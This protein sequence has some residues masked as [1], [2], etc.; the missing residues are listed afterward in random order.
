MNQKAMRFVIIRFMPYIQTREF[1]NIGIVLTCPKTGWFNFQI[2]HRYARLGRFFKHFRADVYRA[3]VKTLTEQ[4]NF[5]KQEL[6]NKPAEQY[7]F[8]LDH[9]ALPREAIIQTSTVGISMASN[10]Q[11]ELNRLFAY[12]VEHSF[13]T[14]GHE[15]TLINS[16]K[17]NVLKPLNLHIPFTQHKIGN[18]EYHETLPLVQ[19]THETKI[20]KIIK[21]IYLGHSSPADIYKKSDTW[22]GKFKRLKDFG[23]IGQD[24]EILLPYIPPEHKQEN[25]DNALLSVL[26]A[27]E[28]HHLQLANHEDHEAIRRFALG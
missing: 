4:L 1:A 26:Q 6:H 23:F 18:D 7:R 19:K 25:T 27:L 28:S 14:E 13:A 8:A 2:E 15:K 11:S 22:I 16:I 12:Y 21:P 24:T 10:E 9:L 17:K 5:I 3:A 20:Y